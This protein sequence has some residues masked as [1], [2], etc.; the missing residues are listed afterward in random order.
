MH[1]LFQIRCRSFV[2]AVL[3]LLVTVPFPVVAQEASPSETVGQDRMDWWRDAKFGMFIHWGVYSRAGGEWN[4]DTDHAEWLQLTAKIP[5]AEYTEYARGFNPVQFDAER[6]VGIAKDAGMKYLVIT[7]KHHDGFAMYDSASN[8]HNIVNVS[9]FGR[10]PLKELAAACQKQG[11]R[12]CVYYSLGRDWED[13]DVPT[14]WGD[15]LGW[16]SNLIDFPNESEKDFQ[17]YFD[18]KVK[19][20]VRE[21]LTSYGPIGVMWF[22]TFEQITREQSE[23]LIA[24]IRELQPN[25]IIN[26]R[27]GRD[28]GDY[29][30]AEQE[31]PSGASGDPWETCMTMNGH[32]GYN[33]ADDD[34]RSTQNLLQNLIDIVSKGG[35]YLLNVGPTGE[36][37]IPEPSVTRLNE[38]GDWLSVNAEA[39]YGCGP[40]PFGEEIGGYSETEKDSKGRAKFISKWQWRATTKPG[41]IFVHVF[42]WPDGN[43]TL[44]KIERKVSVVSVLSDPERKP[45]TFKQAQDEVR[46]TL[47]E[48]KS[49]LPTVLCIETLEE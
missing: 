31:I 4:G 22:D 10:D 44:P 38:I 6:W 49:T 24:M 8:D 7:A 21:I 20:Q 19:P 30:T 13:P 45:L 37:V 43:L 34:W 16:R 28:L 32:W 41:K 9:E 25:C 15:R 23:E 11:I 1:S 2:M 17:K 18:R 27:V 35:N 26:D 29:K 36:G 47:P 39:V 40:T 46:I 33:R 3:G 48:R 42:E 12:F 5:L 14:G